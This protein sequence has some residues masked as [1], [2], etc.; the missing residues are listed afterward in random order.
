M[1]CLAYECKYNDGRGRCVCHY[2]MIITDAA[3]CYR[4]YPAELEED[5]KDDQ[6]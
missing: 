5:D 6:T 4:Y 2:D 3:E 1:R